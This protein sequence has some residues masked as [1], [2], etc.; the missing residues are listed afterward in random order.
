MIAK[1]AWGT[2]PQETC[3]VLIEAIA[4]PDLSAVFLGKEHV[5]T[6]DE[7]IVWAAALGPA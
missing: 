2:F 1:K 5:H 6:A 7:A 4:A 3:A